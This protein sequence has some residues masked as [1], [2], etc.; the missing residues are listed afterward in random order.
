M[1]FL[2]S[3]DLASFTRFLYLWAAIGILATPAILITG[4][5]PMS[6]KLDAGFLA[7]FGMIDKRLGWII[8]EAPV[9][10]VI[11][12]FYLRGDNPLN[13]SAIFVAAFLIHYAN[14]ALIYPFRIR[15]TGK[16]MPVCIMLASMS[17]YV[18]NGYLLGYY[19]GSLRSYPPEW[20]YDPRFLLGMGLFIAGL[21]INIT[22][23]NILITLRASG[24]TGYKIP[25]GGLFRYVSCPHYLGECMEWI[26][27]AIMSWCLP[28]A[29]YAGW[30]AL[31]LVAQAINAHRWYRDTFGD[32]YPRSRRAII[33]GVL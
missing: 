3:V 20:L 8:M 16:K 13:V 26:G 4:K 28:G 19:F 7:A 33:P 18:I 6:S 1:Q 9:L 15:V 5:L 17:F 25:Q 10:M 32:A 2:E 21:A 29:V 30:V 31:P 24:E 14:R 22:S 12:F 11:S 27:F 23:D